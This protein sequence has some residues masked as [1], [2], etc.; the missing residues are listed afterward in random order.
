VVEAGAVP[1]EAAADRVSARPLIEL[2]S[3]TKRYGA[4]VAVDDVSMQV[5]AGEVRAI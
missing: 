3:L 4:L 1:A 2:D 5:S